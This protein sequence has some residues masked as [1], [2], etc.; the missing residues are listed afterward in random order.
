MTVKRPRSIMLGLAVVAVTVAGAALAWA[1]TPTASVS[2]TGDYGAGFG[3]PGKP[4]TV[5]VSGYSPGVPVQ[6]RWNGAN[7]PVLAQGT[8]PEFQATVTIPNV[9]DGIYNIVTTGPSGASG[10]TEG[11]VRL[12]TASFKVGEPGA[13]PRP[14]SNPAPGRT[15][16]AG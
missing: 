6:V 13:A 14:D 4:A 2:V 16:S 8:G 10:V 3:P 7:G 5:G 12:G 9:P 11:E 15:P 1:C